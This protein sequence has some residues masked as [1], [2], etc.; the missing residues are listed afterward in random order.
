[1]AG[2][3]IVFPEAV[4]ER[5]AEYGEGADSFV[6]VPLMSDEAAAGPP[7]VVDDA[8]IEG[9]CLIYARWLTNPETTVCV[10]LKGNSMEPTLFDGS[11][12]AIDRSRRDPRELG[13]KIV[14]VRS[15]DG[16]T[17]RR[18][19]LQQDCILFAP[20]NPVP[21]PASSVPKNPT[22]VWNVATDYETGN[23]IVGQVVW[24]WTLFP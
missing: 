12:V 22:V 9:H 10:R 24:A 2:P 19:R 8:L 16:V 23:P 20:S 4:G 14:A 7:L 3:D 15:D 13:D 21:D 18:C 11:I 1:M 17:I 5:L 6:A